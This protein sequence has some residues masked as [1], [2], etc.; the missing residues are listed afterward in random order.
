MSEIPQLGRSGIYVWTLC[1]FT[2]L[3]L[4]TGFSVNIAMFLVF[5]LVSGFIGSPILAT[6]GATITDVYGPAR[7][8]FGICIWASAGVCGPVFG[9]LIGGFVAPVKGWTWTIWIYTWMCVSTKSFPCLYKFGLQT[10]T[11]LLTLAQQ[12]FCIILLFF[13]LSE[14]SAANILHRRAARLRKATGDER[15]KSQSEIDTAHHTTKDRLLVLARA[16]T[17]TFTEPIVFVVDL[18]TA[19]LYGV[20]FTWFESFPLVFGGIYGFE[21]KMQGLVYL[22]LFVAMLI[23]VP[24]YLL[25]VKLVLVPSSAKPS[26]RPEHVLPPTWSGALS[27]P[28]C[29]FWYGWSAR[30]SIHWIVPI[31][32]SSLFIIPLVT[33]FNGVL[34]YLGMSYPHYAASVFASNCLFRAL[35]GGVFP[36]FVS[37]HIQINSM[38]DMLFVAVTSL[39]I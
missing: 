23:V 18:Y 35:F 34:N 30:A 14:T 11:Q 15:L 20:L 6:G 36:L 4:P 37:S 38:L 39:C 1:V 5:R 27:L 25:W 12:A 3:Q 8:A 16:F 21:A 22:G 32:G 7:A 9:P 24:L 19:L 31:I 28:I 10:V 2:L 17:L 33:F 29:L 26:F 13:L